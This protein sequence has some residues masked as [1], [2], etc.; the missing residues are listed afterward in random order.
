VAPVLTLDGSCSRPPYSTGNACIEQLV[1]LPKEG[2]WP[3][4]R[5]V[6]GLVVFVYV[7]CLTLDPLADEKQDVAFRQPGVKLPR[8]YRPAYND[9]WNA[10]RSGIIPS[11]ADCAKAEDK[12]GTGDCLD[13]MGT[14]LSAPGNDASPLGTVVCLQN[15]LKPFSRIL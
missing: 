14:L 7:D 5:T 3:T 6:R 8:H 2:I 1:D 12:V 9:H 11:N 13:A 15:S 10:M 4:I